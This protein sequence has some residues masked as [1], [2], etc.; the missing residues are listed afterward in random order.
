MADQLDRLVSAG[1][2]LN[3][4]D[5]IRAGLREAL[6]RFAYDTTASRIM[7]ARVVSNYLMIHHPNEIEAIV[8]FGSVAAGRDTPESDIDVLVII[9]GSTSYDA[10]LARV[11]E[12]GLITRGIDEQ[13][14]LHHESDAD[15]LLGL[16]K[17]FEFE[18][19]IVARGIL[20]SGAF[21]SSNRGRGA[22]RG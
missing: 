4:N 20:L 16:E 19:G 13:V 18:T 21:P 6:K 9:K 11:R 8:L 10:E 5:G 12:V 1:I 17:G 7:L 3:R 14:S 2:F 15:F 22:S